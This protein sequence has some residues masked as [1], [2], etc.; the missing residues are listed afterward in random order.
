MK[1]SYEISVAIPDGVKCKFSGSLLECSKGNTQLS[2]AFENPNLVLVV[3]EKEILIKCNKSNRKSLA[4][5]HS[6]A[7]H[8]KNMLHGLKERFV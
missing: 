5:S 7:S 8:I 3:D 1:K 4:N 6:Y 2:K